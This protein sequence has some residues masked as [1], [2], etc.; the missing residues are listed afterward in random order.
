MS[1][2]LKILVLMAL[3]IPVLAGCGLLDLFN[4]KPKNELQVQLNQTFN[5]KVGQ[6]ATVID[7]GIT[8][9]FVDILEDSRCPVDVVCVWQGNAKVAL[10]VRE[11]GKGAQ[12]IELNSTSDPREVFF[13]D[14]RVDFVDI[15]PAKRSN[16]NVTK[17]DYI[18][19]LVV[20]DVRRLDL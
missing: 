4:P 14:F 17:G 11:S 10:D 13:G 3:I 8:V 16:Q 7:A 9:L 5:L 1:K 2:F 19:S 12:R 20:K 6:K 15:Q 18:L